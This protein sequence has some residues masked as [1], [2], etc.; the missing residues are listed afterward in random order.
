[1]RQVHWTGHPFVDAGLAALAA[2]VDIRELGDLS[3]SHL[4]RR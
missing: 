3:P 4:N 2:A 1:M